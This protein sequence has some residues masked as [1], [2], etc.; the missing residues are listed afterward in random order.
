MRRLDGFVGV[1]LS[2]WLAAAAALHLYFAGFG[3]PEPLRLAS[4]HLALVV[5]PVF[6]LYPARPV[7]PRERPSVVDWLLAAA[8]IVPSAYI[9]LNTELVYDRSA[10]IDPVTTAQLVF[11]TAMVL[12]ITEAV[13]RS[14]SPTLAVL[15]GIVIAYMFTCHLLP[16]VWYSRR[17]PY[18]QVVDVMYLINGSGVYGQLTGIS[19][20]IIAAFLVFGAFLQGCGMGRLFSNF[21]AFVAGRFIGGPA[22]MAVITSALF[23]TISGSSV[24]NVVVTGPMSIP[25]MKRLGFRPALAAGIEASASVGGAIMPPVMGAAAFVMAETISVPYAEII[26]AAALGAVLYYLNILVAVH[27]ESKRLG[28]AAMPKQDLPKLR[29]LAADAHLVLP[30]ALL[31][32]LMMMRFSPYF[33]A[34]WSTVAMV[35][36]SW[37]RKHTR[38]GPR[39]IFASFADAGRTIAVLAVAVTSAGIIT[40]GLTN[41]GLLLAFTGMIK[42][43]AGDSLFILALL[44]AGTCLF[45]GVGIPTTPSYIITAAIGAPLI[46]E[47]GIP[48]LSIHLF[49]F[50]FAVLADASPPVAPAADAAAAIAGA[51]PMVS[52][53]HAFRLATGG[54]IAGMAFIYEP[55]L[56]LNG[57]LFEIVAVA[58]ALSMSLVL[59]CAGLAGFVDGPLPYWLRAIVFALG[60]FCGLGHMVETWQ[61]A[62]LGVALVLALHLWSRW[63]FG[64]AASSLRASVVQTK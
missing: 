23:G 22:K 45:L 50:Y 47:Y 17:L 6:L 43:T 33:A 48:L 56:T 32:A 31:V 3:F 9:Y 8:A 26:V 49:V 51:S 60:V 19:A 4:L 7:S 62:V 10:F 1:A 11:G 28:I 63:R 44:I 38:M 58:T 14:I 36:V 20:T 42:S 40:A 34:F 18:E 39:Q 46:A 35:G 13:R 12:L 15:M 25:L 21:G 2:L 24:A 53:L 59:I 5:P 61:R 54:F 57:T 29:D 37:F 30:I 55:A 16:G 52:G 64:A 27:F 41:T